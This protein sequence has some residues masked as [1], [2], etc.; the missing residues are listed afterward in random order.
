LQKVIASILEESETPPI[1]IIMGDHG[2]RLYSDFSDPDNACIS[3][4]FSN[5][6]ALYLPGMEADE[7]PFDITSINVFRLI[8]DHY[9][10]TDFG[11]LDNKYYFFSNEGIPFNFKD[12]GQSLNIECDVTP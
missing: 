4:S 12:V 11:L 8:F 7:I 9:F 10:Q 3:E 5:F 2:S 6:L 1:I